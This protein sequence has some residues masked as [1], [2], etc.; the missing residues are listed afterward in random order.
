MFCGEVRGVFYN[1]FER[2]ESHAFGLVSSVQTFSEPYLCKEHWADS[3]SS[4][5]ESVDLQSL[6]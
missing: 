6:L 3:A 4:C 2:H 1:P 5:K